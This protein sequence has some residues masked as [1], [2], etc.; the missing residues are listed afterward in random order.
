[1]L[2]GKRGPNTCVFF[3]WVQ[4]NAELPRHAQSKGLAGGKKVEE[5]V[6]TEVGRKAE[7]DQEVAIRNQSVHRLKADT[8][9]FEVSSRS[10]G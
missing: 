6:S 1:V 9:G 2:A 10:W 8:S 3:S 5:V 4:F 7:D